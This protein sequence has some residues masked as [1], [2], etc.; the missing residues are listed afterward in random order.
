MMVMEVIQVCWGWEWLKSKVFWAK[1]IMELGSTM[2]A[3]LSLCVHK[4][5]LTS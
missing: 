4:L 5:D 1:H 3:T 2:L